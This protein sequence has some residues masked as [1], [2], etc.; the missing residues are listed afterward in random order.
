ML[1]DVHYLSSEPQTLPSRVRTTV[2]MALIGMTISRKREEHE[3]GANCGCATVTL[4]AQFPK[5]FSANTL[6]LNVSRLT[7]NSEYPSNLP[8]AG[9]CILS[10][11]TTLNTLSSQLGFTVWATLIPG[12][13]FSTL[14]LLASV[15]I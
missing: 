7:L 4:V 6:L 2:W 5:F 3:I 15:L 12:S 13:E 1:L 14:A 10:T 8:P 9:P 11:R